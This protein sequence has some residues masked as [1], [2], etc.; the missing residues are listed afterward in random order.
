MLS[1]DEPARY[2]NLGAEIS[3]TLLNNLT[4]DLDYTVSINS[5]YGSEESIP[6]YGQLTS[7]YE[8]SLGRR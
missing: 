3:T 7:M 5:Y 8:F 4:P 1:P 2:L 6:I